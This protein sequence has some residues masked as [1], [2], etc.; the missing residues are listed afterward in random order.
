MTTLVHILQFLISAG[1]IWFFAGLLIESI[2]NVAKRFNQSGFTIAFFVL[3]LL[4]SISEISVLVNSSIQ[5]IPQ[6]S[7]GNLVGASFVIILFLIPFLAIVGR[8]V[9]L[10]N[11][12]HKKNLAAALLITA[13][14]A[15]FLLD[16][17]VT[18]VEGLICIMV[19]VM[20]FYLIRLQR[21]RSSIPK[22][23]EAVEEDLIAKR[24]TTAV[25]VLKIFIGAVFIFLAGHI[26]VDEAVYFSEILK[27]PSSIIG[28]LILS[29]GTNIP[30]IVVAIRSILKKH[31]DIAFGDYLGSA[32]TN[33]MVFGFLPWLNGK[34]NVEASEFIFTALLI[35]IGFT[36]FFIAS[37]TSNRITKKEGWWLIS[38][39]ALF[40]IVQLVNIIRFAGE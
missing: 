1:V 3:G 21:S 24:N 22:V 31:K 7:A 26:L 34:F 19:Y 13:L 14:P 17:S 12:L 16:G 10:K 11:T 28:L 23:I 29:I 6:V 36:G 4:T 18:R 30:E 32:V 8:G 35:I 39:Y 20:L 37:Q 5:G 38:I 2:N 9:L 25:D 15:L 40:V 27:I 33:T